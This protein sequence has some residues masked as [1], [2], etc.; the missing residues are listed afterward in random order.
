MSEVYLR[1]F[2]F[3]CDPGADD[4]VAL[5]YLLASGRVPLFVTV[6]DG[7]T[8]AAT[9]AKIAASVLKNAGHDTI[10]VLTGTAAVQALNLVP[11]GTDVL[12]TAPLT[13]IAAV[14]KQHPNWA[15]QVGRIVIMGG[16]PMPDPIF[17][18]WGNVYNN[19]AEMN[20]HR[21]PIAAQTVLSAGFS[22]LTLVG[23]N[24]TR[25]FLYGDHVAGE[26]LA[27]GHPFAID[28]MRLLSESAAL[29]G[30][31]YKA[32]RTHEFEP[33]HPVHDVLAAFEFLHPFALPRQRIALAFGKNGEIRP[34]VDGVMTTCVLPEEPAVV[35]AKIMQ[36]FV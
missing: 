8:P 25:P 10:S 6:T 33:V 30:D 12:A 29:Y 20:F 22:D 24:A 26:I 27:S 34:D 31:K 5:Y 35:W 18:E 16:C 14:L 32:F 28:V 2:I 17:G 7:N 23:L 13:N 4:A 11:Q 36:A 19:Q 3:D 9:G 21:D 15:Q 1:P